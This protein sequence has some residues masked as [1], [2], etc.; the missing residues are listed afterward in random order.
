MH[1]DPFRNNKL[2]LQ[3]SVHANLTLCLIIWHHNNLWLAATRTPHHNINCVY[4]DTRT[5]TCICCV[6]VNK[7]I[8]LYTCDPNNFPSSSSNLRSGKLRACITN[9]NHYV[10]LCAC[11]LCCDLLHSCARFYKCNAPQYVYV[12]RSLCLV[13]IPPQPASS[14]ICKV[15]NILLANHMSATLY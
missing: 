4:I 3:H 1:L 10:H 2:A 8:S 6:G 14:C 7:E 9:N 13:S 15:S 5:H 11:V 12:I